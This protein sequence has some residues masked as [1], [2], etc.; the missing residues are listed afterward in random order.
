MYQLAVNA[1]VKDSKEIKI[2]LTNPTNVIEHL[3][4]AKFVA[5]VKGDYQIKK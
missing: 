1:G 5:M 3:D 2:I 4:N